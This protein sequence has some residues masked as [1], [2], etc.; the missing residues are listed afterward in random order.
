M[1]CSSAAM[2]KMEATSQRTAG[3][4]GRGKS[5]TYSSFIYRVLK[6]KPQE[7][8]IYLCKESDLILSIASEAARLSL[9]NKRRIITRQEVETAIKTVTSLGHST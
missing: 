1:K 2:N 3:G 9:Y 8:A 4:K 6:Q 5:K 7:Q